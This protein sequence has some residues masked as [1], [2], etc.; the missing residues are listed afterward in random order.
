MCKI[1][2]DKNA[3]NQLAWPILTEEEK[4]EQAKRTNTR[5]STGVSQTMN[6][7]FS[8]QNYAK[9]KEVDSKIPHVIKA[10]KNAPPLLT[11]FPTTDETPA[12]GTKK[13][14]GVSV[15]SYLP[16]SMRRKK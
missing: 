5:F 9:T 7:N 2:N 10:D 1:F 4:K 8:S 6:N 14:N 12:S 15:K 16:T 3:V 11:Y 13:T